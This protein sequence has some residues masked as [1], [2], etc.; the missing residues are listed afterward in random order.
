M[1]HVGTKRRLRVVSSAIPTGARAEW[2]ISWHLGS[3]RPVHEGWDPRP[4]R[5]SNH[6]RRLHR[7]RRRDLSRGLRQRR[8]R[9]ASGESA[10]RSSG[11]RIENPENGFAVVGRETAGAA[12]C[13]LR[14]PVASCRPALCR[15][16]GTRRTSQPGRR[17]VRM[18]L[19]CGH[20]AG[21]LVNGEVVIINA[22]A[23]Q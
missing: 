9:G 6:C 15:C 1:I 5:P 19:K 13:R 12:C 16:A 18:S 22:R 14:R 8:F 21:H 2:P 4:S 10:R 20:A 23:V 7:W 17:R 3:C 11:S